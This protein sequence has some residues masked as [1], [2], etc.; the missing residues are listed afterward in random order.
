[1]IA[2]KYRIEIPLMKTLKTNFYEL[3][4]SDETIFD[5]FLQ[6]ALDGLIYYDLKS[7]GNSWINDKLLNVLG[8]DDEYNISNHDQI[9]TSQIN[10]SINLLRLK[11]HNTTELHF[12]HKSGKSVWMETR[13]IFYEPNKLILALRNITQSK[14][15]ELI[16]DSCNQQ[17][18][19]G[20]WEIDVLAGT[21]PV[22]SS[23]TREIHEVDANYEPLLENAILFY[24][25]GSCRELISEL[26]NR[27]VSEGTPYLVELEIVTAKGNIKWVKTT[28]VPEF[29]DGKCIRTYGTFQDITNEKNLTRQLEEEKVKLSNAIDGARIATWEWNVQTG[30]TV[31][32]KRWAEMLGYTLDELAPVSIN[33]W[34]N[35]AHPDD[36]K[37]SE[38]LLNDC[39]SKKSAYYEGEFRMK[40]KNGDW[41]WVYD[42][43]KVFSWTDDGKPLMMYGI[44]LD[45]T[46]KIN[47]I[48]Q[49]IGFIK[50]APSAIAMFDIDMRYMAVSEQWVKDYGLKDVSE[51]IG[52][53]HY[54]LL[55]EIGD[56]WKAIHQKCLN[57]RKSVKRRR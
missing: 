50:H 17:A 2:N 25:E 48:D 12:K 7:P 5:F 22:W 38:K 33:T 18:H 47:E 36:L 43:G 34:L 40:H 30:T 31:F 26:Y 19:I 56:D 52:K 13:S 10:D 53:T 24:R 54:E 29:I 28:C 11:K 3:L 57:R 42:K 49:Y 16:L 39:F 35:L 45:I 37:K 20:Y 32:N 51:V 6:Y 55:P 9:L 21:K 41:I 15:R 4:K 27:A 1:L 8:F 23:V 46:E 14:E 44:H